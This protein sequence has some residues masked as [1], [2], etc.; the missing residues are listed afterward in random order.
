MT[1][2]CS[3]SNAL[4]ATARPRSPLSLAAEAPA[5]VRRATGLSGRLPGPRRTPQRARGDQPTL[6]DVYNVK[7]VQPGQLRGELTFHEITLLRHDAAPLG[8]NAGALLVDLET[9]QVIGMQSTG[10]FLETS[11]AVPLYMLR[12]DPL[13]RAAGVHFTDATPRDRQNVLDQVERLARSRFWNETRSL[14]DNLYN[15]A[16]GYDTNRRTG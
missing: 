6:P 14:I 1:W 15:A 8:Q 16:F 10:R 3:K 5:S 7:R 13:M 12:D 4:R 11:T 2:P 9:Q